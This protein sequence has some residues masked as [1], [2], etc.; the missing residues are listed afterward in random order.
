MEGLRISVIL[1]CSFIAGMSTWALIGSNSSD[2]SD[3][4]HM[5]AA[6][7]CTDCAACDKSADTAFLFSR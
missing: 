7:D 2:A 3:T 4:E 6:A 5:V 1:M